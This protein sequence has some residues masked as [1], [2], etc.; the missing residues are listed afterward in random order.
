MAKSTCSSFSSCCTTILFWFSILTVVL[1]DWYDNQLLNVNATWPS[2]AKM[3]EQDC[4]DGNV[5]DPSSLSPFLEGPPTVYV[6]VNHDEV[7]PESYIQ[8]TNQSLLSSKYLVMLTLYNQTEASNTLYNDLD[9][10]WVKGNMTATPG[11]IVSDN[12]TLVTLNNETEPLLPYSSDFNL[13]EIVGGIRF[14]QT[15][16]QLSVGVYQQTPDFENYLYTSFADGGDPKQNATLLLSI[17][18]NMFVGTYYGTENPSRFWNSTSPS[19]W[20]RIYSYVPGTLDSTSTT[21]PGAST[22]S[23]PPIATTSQAAATK[24]TIY[25][26]TSKGID[27]LSTW[28]ISAFSAVL[29][30]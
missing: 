17:L 5:S 16:W 20:G 27:F 7:Y 18:R 10:L 23:S 1:A 11:A 6:K 26:G 25:K 24:R 19:P 8:A 3:F 22:A 4:C 28:M 21:Q 30:I 13:S 9:F 29:F 15:T 12:N 14:D 2:G